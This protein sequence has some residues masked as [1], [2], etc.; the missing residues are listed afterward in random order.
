MN[1]LPRQ[2]LCEIIKI[3]GKNA[4]S[5]HKRIRGLLNDFCC[6]N[7]PEVNFLLTA[8]EEQVYAELVAPSKPIP[9]EMLS[10]RLVK[11][12]CTN[13][14]MAE[15]IA[16]W[17]VDSWA[18]ALGVIT[19]PCQV[20]FNAPPSSRVNPKTPVQQTMVV[21]QSGGQYTTI[22]EA[23]RNTP[24]DTLILVK[25]GYYY[26]GLIIDKRIKIKGDGPRERIIVESR[27]T[28]CIQM[29]TDDEALVQGLTLRCRATHTNP[30]K[31]AVEVPMG[32]L[33]LIECDITSDTACVAIRGLS[34][35]PEIQRC[36]FHD[37]GASGLFIEPHAQGTIEDCHVFRNELP[38]ISIQQYANPVI[39]RCKVYGGKSHG[40]LIWEN[41]SGTIE[42]C[43]IY[44]NARGGVKVREGGTP[45]VRGCRIYRNGQQEE[46]VYQNGMGNTSFLKTTE[47][48]GIRQQRSHPEIRSEAIS[49]SANYTTQNAAWQQEI[50]HQQEIARQ[51]AMTRQPEK[52]PN[53]I[54]LFLHSI[55]FSKEK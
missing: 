20:P 31:H 17:A 40:I 23:I 13:R 11:R 36:W 47:P 39:K 7:Y 51:Q 25:P 9:Y 52:R 55:G 34:A 35:R 19:K 5:D 46:W 54:D 37:A 50:A 49:T 38:G 6:G 43:D 48:S 16:R 53:L 21:S 3:Y 33:R 41:G 18:L 27:D 22:S 14:G 10:A 4:C 2:K 44:E 32:R 45:I 1:N 24:P 28:S 15:E 12:L 42:D 30:K 8:L 26:E 29:Q